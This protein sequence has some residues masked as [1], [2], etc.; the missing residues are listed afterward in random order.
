MHRS[1]Q[2]TLIEYIVKDNL[3]S[4]KSNEQLLRTETTCRFNH[5]LCLSTVATPKSQQLKRAG[6]ASFVMSMRLHLSVAKSMGLVTLESNRSGKNQL[7]MSDLSLRHYV[8]L[9]VCTVVSCVAG[10][11]SRLS[12]MFLAAEA[13]KCEKIWPSTR[14]EVWYYFYVGIIW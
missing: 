4:R 7:V 3:F 11:L 1:P 12:S 8:L 10:C 9:T 5:S 2:S 13:G 6:D 14:K